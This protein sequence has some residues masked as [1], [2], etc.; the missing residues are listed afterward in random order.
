MVRANSGP[1]KLPSGLAELA[2]AMA[3]RTS[4][5]LTPI[6]AIAIGIDPDAD[7]RLLGAVDA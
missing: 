7:R 6:E 2:L 1:S 3:V 5:M 4:S